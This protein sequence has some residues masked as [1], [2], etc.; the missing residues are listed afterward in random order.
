MGW[1]EKVHSDICLA[2]FSCSSMNQ[3]GL[4]AR[5]VETRMNREITPE[6]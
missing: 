5:F 3:K 4:M 6:P 2:F 1:Y